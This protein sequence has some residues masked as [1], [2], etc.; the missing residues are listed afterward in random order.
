MTVE[1]TDSKP[2]V[3]RGR[4]KGCEK[5]AGSGRKPGQLNKTTKDVREAIAVFAQNNVDN[6][7]NWLNAVSD[8]AKKMDLFL[9]A[10]EYH[11]P[12]LQRSEMVGDPSAPLQVDFS[13]L[14]G[15]TDAELAILQTMLSKASAKTEKQE[16]KSKAGR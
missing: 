14:K 5:P 12:K 1:T 16:A 7:T 9:R 10:V 4:K 2:V 8:P 6:M 3:K 13:N 11:I 15:L